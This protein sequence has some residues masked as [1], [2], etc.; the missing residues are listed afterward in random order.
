ML[1]R[2]SIDILQT[3]VSYCAGKSRRTPAPADGLSA[4]L[5]KDGE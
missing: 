3:L 5:K 4:S 1:S 2:Q